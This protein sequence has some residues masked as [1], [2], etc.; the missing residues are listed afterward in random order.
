MWRSM[1]DLFLIYYAAKKVLKSYFFQITIDDQ[2]QNIIVIIE[3]AWNEH[4]NTGIHVW[5]NVI[6]KLVTGL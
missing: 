4:I 6:V 3:Y 2:V 5:I 1:T